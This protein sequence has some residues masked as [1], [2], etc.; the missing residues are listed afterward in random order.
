M[1]ENDYIYA[2]DCASVD[3]IISHLVDCDSLF[4]PPL[5]SRVNITEYAKKIH[6]NASSHE[7]WFGS[8]LIA[9][10]A[11]Y[12]NSQDI[13]PA[14]ITSVSVC[15][16]HHGKGI[17]E[18]LLKEALTNMSGINIKQVTLEVSEDSYKPISLYKKL[19]FITESLDN[20]VIT[21]SLDLLTYKGEI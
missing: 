17:A 11:F 6:L 12:K 10:I 21:M 20:G 18:S 8:T 19:G 13:G 15:A 1:S 7:C 16:A 9:L 2:Q 3:D 4:T 14:Y 5:S